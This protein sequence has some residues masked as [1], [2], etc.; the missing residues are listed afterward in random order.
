MTWELFRWEYTLKVF[1]VRLRKEVLLNIMVYAQE[2]L[3]R[4]G[5]HNIAG[6]RYQTFLQTLQK[7]DEVQVKRMKKYLKNSTWHFSVSQK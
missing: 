2:G 6:E 7:F 1:S 4:E 5:I 3:G